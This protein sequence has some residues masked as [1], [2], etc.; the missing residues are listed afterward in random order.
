MPDF[1]QLKSQLLTSGIQSQNP[2]LYQV[3][4]TLL[5]YLGNVPGSSV[6]TAISGGGTPGPPGPIGPSGN[7]GISVLGFDGYDG[8]DGE[9]GPPGLPGSTGSTGPSGATG[10]TGNQGPPGMDGI[11]GEN[12]YEIVPSIPNISQLLDQIGNV[13]GSILYRDAA[14]G[15]QVLLPGVSTYLLQTN[16][17][18]N[19]PS[20]V[21]FGT[22][23]SI[24]IGS[25]QLNASQ[26]Q[27]LNTVPVTIIPAAGSG[28]VIVPVMALFKGVRSGTAF[29]NDSVIRVQ[30]SGITTVLFQAADFTW[31]SAVA[32][33]LFR[34]PPYNTSGFSGSTTDDP[35]DQPLQ[36]VGTQAMTGGTGCTCTIVVAYYLASGL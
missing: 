8:E 6:A 25:V 11:D 26:L 23:P 24:Q 19:N 10:A 4:N 32:A 34:L 31:N 9:I 12:V 18:N 29:V 5:S 16:G 21:N 7:P 13:Q 14:N 20:W 30:W 15:W 35:R 17:A 36:A 3:I 1:T 27:S 22:L 33:T 2:S 28:V